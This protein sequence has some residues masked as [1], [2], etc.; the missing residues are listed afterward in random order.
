MEEP[1]KE[2]YEAVEFF[3]TELEH[4][5]DGRRIITLKSNNKVFCEALAG[6]EFSPLTRVI[7]YVKKGGNKE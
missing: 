7:L 1:I 3:I 6:K 5:F 4:P 2:L